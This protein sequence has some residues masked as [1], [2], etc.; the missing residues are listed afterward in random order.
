[1]DSS[2][3]SFGRGRRGDKDGMV[4]ARSC[5]RKEFEAG[6]GGA[7]LTTGEEGAGLID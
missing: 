2:V 6:E 3:G 5:E 4:T 7:T 1:M